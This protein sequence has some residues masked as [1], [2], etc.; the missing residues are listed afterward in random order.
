M[1][2]LQE[3]GLGA[4]AFQPFEPD[5]VSNNASGEAWTKDMTAPI[6]LLIGSS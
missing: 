2:A 3:A 1:L 5:D 6:R 4:R